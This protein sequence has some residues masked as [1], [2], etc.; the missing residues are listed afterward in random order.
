MTEAEREAVL[1]DL[2]RAKVAFQL[3]AVSTALGLAPGEAA[4]ATARGASAPN[5]LKRRKD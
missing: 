2:L 3:R 4:S 1:R 5:S